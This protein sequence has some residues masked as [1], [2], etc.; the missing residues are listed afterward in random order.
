MPETDRIEKNVVL[1]APLS[2]VWAAISRAEEFGA[3]FGV[4]FDGPFVEGKTVTGKIAPTKVDPEIAKMQEPHAG[5]PFTFEIA[6]IEPM[7]RLAFKWHP[8]AIEKGRD[9]SKETPTLV[10]F[11]LEEASGGTKLTIVESGFDEIPL[12]R[13]AKAFAANEGGWE[14]Q[15]SLVRKWLEQNA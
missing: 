10:T 9:Y 13:R 11:S 6:T 7:K 3:W 1:K 2:R 4:D 14:A 12:E 5:T 8:F 15:T